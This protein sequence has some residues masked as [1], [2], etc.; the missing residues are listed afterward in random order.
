MAYIYAFVVH[1]NWD[2]I[3]L[4]NYSSMITFIIRLIV[5]IG[6]KCNSTIPE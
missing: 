6:S 5:A 1:E 4:H 3:V 2:N